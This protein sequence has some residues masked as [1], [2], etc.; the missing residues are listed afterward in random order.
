M[1]TLSDRLSTYRNETNLTPRALNS[2]LIPFVT[3]LFFGGV[4]GVPVIMDWLELPP[5][6]WIFV[7]WD[8][9]FPTDIPEYV[10]RIGGIFSFIAFGVGILKFWLSDRLI[11]D[12]RLN[13]EVKALRTDDWIVVVVWV[14][15]MV[16]IALLIDYPLEPVPAIQG[17][18]M[19]VLQLF[20]TT[21][22]S[23]LTNT[24]TVPDSTGNTFVKT[25][26]FI[27]TFVLA[28]FFTHVVLFAMRAAE[29]YL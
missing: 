9:W 11:E 17:I 27:G 19:V 2:T 20:F 1:S 26:V 13:G 23:Y 6:P 24:L 14:A 22:P 8:F 3:V 12:L 25:K 4:A 10:L 16:P 15:F 18:L 5:D 7:I 29:F 28:F 21:I